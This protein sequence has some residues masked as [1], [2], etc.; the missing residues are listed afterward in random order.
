MAKFATGQIDEVKAWSM[1]VKET[2]E[3]LHG[4]SF[5][6]LDI[7][8]RIPFTTQDDALGAQVRQIAARTP[9]QVQY[10]D[11]LSTFGGSARI[12]YNAIKVTPAAR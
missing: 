6:V 11:Q 1:P 5:V 8:E 3:V 12:K 10:R 2:G 7:G 4:V 9:V